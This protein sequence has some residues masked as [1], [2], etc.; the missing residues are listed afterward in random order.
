ML[1]PLRRVHY[2][3][4]V[5][6]ASMCIG[7]LKHRSTYDAE[8]SIARSPFKESVEVYDCL[9]CG[10]TH[11]GRRMSANHRSRMRAYLTVKNLLD[12]DFAD[13]VERATAL[14]NGKYGRRMGK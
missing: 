13:S 1:K 11:V 9:F 14:K 10:Y 3:I 12:Y 8:K 6:Q 2:Y 7:K 5:I 4:D